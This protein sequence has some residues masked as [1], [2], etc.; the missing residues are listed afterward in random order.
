MLKKI[1]IT[2]CF[3]VTVLCGTLLFHWGGA[4]TVADQMENMDYGTQLALEKD[5]FTELGKMSLMST[6]MYY[7]GVRLYIKIQSNETN[8]T[9]DEFYL[10][11]TDGLTYVADIMYQISPSESVF[12]WNFL[13]ANEVSYDLK[14]RKNSSFQ[15]EI[16]IV[17]DKS[18]KEIHKSYNE[19]L[20]KQYKVGETSSY[21]Y[22][23]I[24]KN[25]PVHSVQLQCGHDIV[26]GYRKKEEQNDL[27][28]V[29][30]YPIREG[31][32]FTI[33]VY[34]EDGNVVATKIVCF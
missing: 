34:G 24:L 28:L 2:S 16:H 3:L 8:A 31:E 5:E 7:D 15:Q 12:I 21:F 20:V 32:Q 6:S 33:I 11:G 25:I 10:E 19:L 29:V 26:T 27:E 17:N 18:M 30:P 14:T 13:E 9:S 4:R 23:K 22:V 1:I